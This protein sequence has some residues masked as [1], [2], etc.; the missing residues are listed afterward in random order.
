M[1]HIHF[2]ESDTW[3]ISHEEGDIVYGLVMTNQCANF[4]DAILETFSSENLMN[5]RLREL[6]IE[7]QGDNS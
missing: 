5:I 2:P 7:T 1:Y 4:N 6:G 3:Y